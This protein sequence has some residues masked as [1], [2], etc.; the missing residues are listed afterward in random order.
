MDCFRITG[1]VRLLGRVRASG[2]KNAALPIMAAALLVDG[3]ITLKRVPD[4]ADVNTLALLLGQ[5]GVE[6]K[7]DSDGNLRIATVDPT[8]TKADYDLVRRMRAS[9]CVLGPLVAKRG[10]GVVSL[11]GGCNIGTRPVDLHLAGLSALGAEVRIEHGYVIAAAKRLRGADI[12]LRGPFGPTV[13]GTANVMS[14]ATLAVGRTVIRGAATEPEIVDLGNFLIAMGAQIFGLGTETIEIIGVDELQPTQYRIIPDRIEVGTLLLAGAITG[15]CVT[16]EEARPG[17][18]AAVLAALAA[19]GAD[20]DCRADNV[21]VRAAGRPRPTNIR[22]RPYPGVPTDLQA[23]FMALLSLSTGESL[24]SDSVFADRFMQVAEL[25][26]LGARIKRSGSS[27]TVRGVRE[28]SGASVMASDLRASAALVLAGLAAE[29]ETIVRRIYHL[30]R[31]YQRLEQKLAELGARILR[32]R[33]QEAFLPARH[34]VGPQL[35][36]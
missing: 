35:V 13:T 11:P 29:R 21:T 22:A 31:G 20:I 18:L 36:R 3:P 25:N 34:L 4:L 33:D 32:E 19:T 30:D 17:H 7:R 27:A 12:N 15:G 10:R 8:P 26:R 9:F 6:V 16:V 14:A 1:G 24:I 23:Q 5:L 28:L 2:S